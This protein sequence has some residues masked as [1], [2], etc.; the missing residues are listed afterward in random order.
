[1]AV[2]VVVLLLLLVKGLFLP[3]FIVI[4]HWNAVHR[5]TDLTLSFA[6]DACRS[7]FFFF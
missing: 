1:M 2:L 3:L 5:F 6:V 7:F 4:L